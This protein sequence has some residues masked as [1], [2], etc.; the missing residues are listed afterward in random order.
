MKKKNMNSRISNSTR[1]F[2]MKSE[3]RKEKLKKTLRSTK[4]K[5]PSPT[6]EQKSTIFIT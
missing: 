4:K 1:K 2:R 6:K 3:R 5:L